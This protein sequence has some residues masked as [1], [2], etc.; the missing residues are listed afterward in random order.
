MGHKSTKG[1]KE[2][3]NSQTNAQDEAAL[4]MKERRKLQ[5]D[6]KF[7]ASLVIKP[8]VL[9][10]TPTIKPEGAIRFVVLSDTHNQAKVIHSFP[11]LHPGHQVNP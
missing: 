7:I 9:P 5:E 4:M 3:E 1:E 8:L 10:D 6:E 11:F 2:K